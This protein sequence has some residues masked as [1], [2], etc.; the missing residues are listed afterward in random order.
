[1]NLGPNYCK[2]LDLCSL[3]FDIAIWSK[4]FATGHGIVSIRGEEWCPPCL[5]VGCGKMLGNKP[6]AY[7]VGL[8][9]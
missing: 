8:E 3:R 7:K 6:F 9:K 5:C 2:F 4:K 1:M